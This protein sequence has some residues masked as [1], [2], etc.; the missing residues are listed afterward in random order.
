MLN[1]HVPW[2]KKKTRFIKRNATWRSGSR[3]GRNEGNDVPR[4][5]HRTLVSVRKYA[6]LVHSERCQLIVV[7]LETGSGRSGEAAEFI[8]QLA[9]SRAG[10]PLLAETADEDAFHFFRQGVREFTGVF[11]I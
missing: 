5:T 3:A 2:L 11:A 9:G 7:G 8:C 6:E 4:V 10:G 1:T